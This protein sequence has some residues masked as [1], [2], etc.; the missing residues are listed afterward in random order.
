MTMSH[1]G[2]C[3]PLIFVAMMA[4]A[5][6][7]PVGPDYQKTEPAVPSAYGSVQTGIS[8]CVA[9]GPCYCGSWWQV[10]RD[11]VLDQ[12]MTRAV[13]GNPDIR[14]ARARVQQARALAG[15]SAAR[16]L[17]EGGPQGS[18]DVYRRSDVMVPTQ[19]G[20]STPSAFRRR[21]ELYEVG[22][23]AS[24]EIDIFGGV[25]REMEAADADLD[26]AGEGLRDVL[27]TLQG[28]VAR[29]YMTLRG[30]QLRM[31]I[32]QRELASRRTNAAIT[33]SRFNAGLV[34]HLEL[35]RA[36]G[37]V[38]VAESRIPSIENGILAAVHRLGVLLGREPGS[39]LSS[40]SPPAPLPTIPDDLPA[41]LPSELLRQRP[42]IRKAEREVAAATARIGVS[43]ADLFPRFSLTG[44]FGYLDDDLDS[45]SWRSGHFWGF[46]PSIRWPILNFKRI[47]SQIA[48]KEAV[49]D[50]ALAQYENVVLLSLEEVENALVVLSREKRRAASL[51]VAVTAN[52]EAL[53]LARELY[54]A[55]AESYLAILDAESALFTAE[56][57]LARSR[58]NRAVGFVSLYKAL[59]GGWQAVEAEQPPDQTGG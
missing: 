6:C 33:E 22:F 4:L 18:Y 15:V 36:Q 50:E 20:G 29:N 25:R 42:D 31:D 37:E 49:R 48:A 40:L 7:A 56:D 17:P 21:G 41:G 3:V 11:P 14:M 47:L 44:Y 2:R 28:E 27:V 58:I 53:N 51:A 9:P 30:E 1:C 23:D 16:L 35:A 59:G 43:T 45:L 32:A 38:A 57:E 26:A 54:T 55:G 8:T 24:W 39:L 19:T 46:G 34:S 13:E 10:L 5:G 52:D 12:L